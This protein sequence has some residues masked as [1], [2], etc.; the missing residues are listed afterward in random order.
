MDVLFNEYGYDYTEPPE[1]RR[2]KLNEIVAEVNDDKQKVINYLTIINK[3]ILSRKIS[4]DIAYY[5]KNK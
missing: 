5:N 1:I 3:Q 4:N 2:K